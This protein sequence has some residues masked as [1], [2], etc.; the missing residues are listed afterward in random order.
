[1]VLGLSRK[2]AVRGAGVGECTIAV[3]FVF[4]DSRAGRV[5]RASLAGSAEARA[6]AQEE[7]ADAPP[8]VAGRGD[9]QS[10]DDGPRSLE[11]RK[12]TS[13]KVPESTQDPRRKRL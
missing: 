11:S 2:A 6:P 5:T 7:E 4:E 12:V 13:G 9:R 10:G 8:E 1:M 3:K